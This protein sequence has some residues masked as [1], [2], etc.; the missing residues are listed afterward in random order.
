MP[1]YD[2][3]YLH[4]ILTRA[5]S[6]PRGVKVPTLENADVLRR[7]CYVYRRKLAESGD[8]RF[9]NLRFRI[10]PQDPNELWIIKLETADGTTQNHDQGR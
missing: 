2:D 8:K 10:G 9:L 1:V 7:E 4:G 5:L 6:S 3:E